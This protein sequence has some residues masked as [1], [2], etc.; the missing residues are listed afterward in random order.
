MR[1]ISLLSFLLLLLPLL[2]SCTER[3]VYI[4]YFG[5][6]SGDKTLQEIHD[7]H[8]SFLLSVKSTEEEAKLSLLY[9]YK[10]S[11]N[12]FA[13]LLTPDEAAKLSE[14]DE[15]VSVFPSHANKWSLQ[16]T[17]S[18]EFVGLE[19]GTVDWEHK[20]KR[21][22]LLHEAKYGQDIVVGLLDSGIWPESK[23][24]SDEG[25][26][27]IPKSWK[28]ICQTGDDF[29]SSHCN[30][31]MDPL[32][33]PC[34][35]R[36]NKVSP[37]LPLWVSAFLAK[38]S[39]M[40]P[41]NSNTILKLIGARYYLKGY[42]AHYGTL[43][44]TNEYRSPRDHDGHGTHTSSTVG[45]RRVSNVSALGGFASGTAKGGAP[46]V[47]LAM[48]KVC[49]PIPGKIA[50]AGNTCTNADMLAAIDDAI[51]DG[52]DVLSISI[53]TTE[54]LPYAKDGIAIG[55]L[56][57]AKRNIVV[58]CSAGN[59]GPAPSTASNLAPWIITVGA[60]SVDRIFSSPVVLGS[61]MIVKGQTVTPYKLKKKMYP[62]VYAG[63]V[64][65]PGTAK[66]YIAGQCLPG[67][68]SPKAVKGKIVL[69]LRGNGTRVGKG[70]EVK[71]AGGA[72]MILGNSQMNGAEISVDAHVLPGTAV[73]SGDATTILNYINFTNKP[74]ATIVPARTVLQA[75]PA[76]FM[77]AFSSTGPNPLEP[78]VLKPDITA[79]GLNI[80][81]A[82]SEASSAT[83]LPDD[84]RIVKY[85]IVSGTSMSCPHVAA[86][87]A[88]IKAIHPRWSSAA[89]KSALMTTAGLKNNMD[90]PLTDAAGN[91]ANP[92]NFG[93]GHFQPTEA[94]DPGLVYDASYTDYLLF[95]CS[96]RVQ[97]LDPSFKCPNV[98]PSPSNLNSPSLA[99][100]KLNGTMTV[101][102]TVTN[103][104]GSKSLYSVTITP[105]LGF[106]VKISPMV[107][108]FKGVGE[109]K[110][111]T[112]TV[113][114]EEEMMSR[115]GMKEEY[116]FG[117]YTW[118]DSIHTVR[119]PMA[120]SSA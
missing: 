94:V 117:W 11:I 54:T 64:V 60:S 95:L 58:A 97:N 40:T 37:G 53:G 6:H 18:W 108:F 99:I 14:R 21:G 107:L 91:N 100:S 103:V 31:V 57:A 67:S 92:F 89:V 69:C 52:V 23:S 73:V 17:R 96:S 19:E 78:N 10:N 76:P 33:K 84:H 85:N 114:A 105:P 16:T 71:R 7:T 80:L 70:M 38:A 36:S 56:H 83:K 30:R 65:V 75:Q 46:L 112:V 29:N 24:F 41:H 109:K 34:R 115:R 59:S 28:G 113:K 12:G 111:F 27:P 1:N 3:Q 104:G 88:L 4:V 63:N 74:T 87:A 72:A 9:S 90:K 66:T 25:M 119:S 26:G 106:S 32:Q 20:N 49:W 2:V 13:A 98:S 43:N 68:L 62:L 79:P 5:E 55:A 47:R 102:R 44:T 77:A 82:W 15:V 42:E 118:T 81:A 45:G 86:A 22:S 35:I 61:G 8:H 101:N 93:S 110:S 51:G 48:Y 50:A 39:N 116:V 120:V